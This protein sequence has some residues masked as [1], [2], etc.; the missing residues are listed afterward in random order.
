MSY[1]E[2]PHRALLALGG[3]FLV[4]GFGSIGKLLV[5]PSIPNCE[6]AKSYFLNKDLP[7]VIIEVRPNCW[8]GTF[9]SEDGGLSYGT[10]DGKVPYDAL[11]SDSYIH[12]GNRVVG[13]G[14]EKVTHPL[15]VRF[16]GTG[17]MRIS[18]YRYSS[19]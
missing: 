9:D 1:V 12:E 13:A 14:E 18:L 6:G 3:L 8:S 5:P 2:K 10:I 15:P 19:R 4:L 16:K 7:E 11:F 17:K